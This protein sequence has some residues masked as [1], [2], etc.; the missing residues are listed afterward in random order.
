MANLSA[1]SDEQCVNTQTLEHLIKVHQIL[2]Q[3]ICER[4]IFYYRCK[5]LE[6][7]NHQINGIKKSR[8]SSE[9]TNLKCKQCGSS[10][11]RRRVK[12]CR[13]DKKVK[14]EVSK[15]KVKLTCNICGFVFCD[16]NS[17]KQQ[18]FNTSSLDNSCLKGS[19]CS[20]P[21]STPGS[22]KR[23]STSSSPLQNAVLRNLIRSN[24]KAKRDTGLLQFLQSC[25]PSPKK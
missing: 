4:N 15:I 13:R 1:I 11:I 25:S 6:R 21:G 8:E 2:S 18:G 12:K 5:I 7:N 17:E 3:E 24:K 9:R 23:L 20:S 19:P 14:L 22:L 16:T 10:D